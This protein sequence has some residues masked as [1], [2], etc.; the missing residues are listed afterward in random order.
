MRRKARQMGLTFLL[1]AGSAITQTTSVPA[2]QNNLAA[3]P[4]P[5]TWP[6]A[7]NPHAT[8]EARAL[9]HFI[10]SISGHYA[11]TGQHNFPN[12][13]SRWTDR[14]YDLTGKYPA[15]FGQDFGFSGGEDKDSVEARPEMI[16]EAERQYAH[17]AVIALTWHAVRP[18]DD[19]PVSSR[20]SV[21]GHLSDFEWHE[22]LTP[23]TDLN[24][25]WCAQVD[26]VAG[27][28][29][30]LQDAHVPVLFRAYH[31]MNGNWFWW[32]GR[33]G[34]DGSAALFR[35]IYDRFVNLHHLDNIV[36][37]WNVNTP[38]PNA[39]SIAD[40]YP[41]PQYVDVLTIDIYGAF[42]AQYYTDMLALAA[43]KPIALGEVG[44]APTPE[45]LASQPRWAYFMVWS[46][47]LDFSNN[48]DAL[49]ALY[50]SPEVLT[51]DDS[52]IAGPLAAMRQ[53]TAE[54][55]HGMPEIE[56]ITPE[57]TEASKTLLARLYG[58]STTGTLSGQENTPQAVTTATAAVT[59]ATG[60]TPAIYG[61]ELGITSDAAQE[62]ATARRAIVEEAGSEHGR[63]AA[64]ALT[65]HA[66]RPTDEPPA[67][68]AKSVRGTL[69]DFEWDQLLTPGT[70]LNKRWCD[71]VDDVAETLRA[72]QQVGIAVL[73][74]PYPEANGH[75]YW[76]AGRKGAHGSAE[77]YRELYRRLVEHD[78]VRNLIWVWQA[79]AP[80]FGPNSPGPLD[81]Y[82]PGLLYVD[83][84][85]L[86]TQ[87]TGN[88]RFRTDA[89]LARLGVGKPIGIELNGAIPASDFFTQQPNWAWF[90]AGTLA[91][92]SQAQA[93]E[94]LYGGPRVV[95]LET[96]H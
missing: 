30:Q 29:R 65:W 48:V 61:E 74:Q 83:A 47:L 16:A 17:G 71:E 56:A 73:F 3:T 51:R 87:S 95:S 10:D 14:A 70:D 53:A 9:L 92:T 28:L 50:H 81:D 93:L 37:V 54:R 45:I 7:V 43:G 15:L 86:S 57:A 49:T 35:Q 42:N 6:A 21:Q 68:D 12:S 38:S 72:L 76:W 52:A 82:F 89:L 69:T 64:I 36:W 84:L 41:G 78:H 88:G 5:A 34:Q 44:A 13:I 90:L 23:G 77:L 79:V 20:D 33:P 1:G 40:Y 32:G 66:L 46:N 25:R 59:E 91:T 85:A 39:G 80:G 4:L 55:T 96:K 19:E 24:K 11:L 2:P 63:G 94:A 8:P 67:S 22:L 60:K 58:S 26:A 18:S 31:E 75:T 27:Y 62:S